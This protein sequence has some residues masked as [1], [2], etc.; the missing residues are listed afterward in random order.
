[1]QTITFECEV[2]TPM[3]LAGADG[4]TPEL[5][6]PSIKGALRFWWRAMNGHKD[7]KTLQEEE[8]KIFGGT[9]GDSGQRSNVLIRVSCDDFKP[10]Y[11]M[12]TYNIKTYDGKYRNINVLFYL[13]YGHTEYKKIEGRGQTV[14]SHAFIP[15]KTKF[16]VTLKVSDE[17]KKDMIEAFV[18]VSQF[19]G[20]GSKSRNGFGC[21]S[22]NQI[23]DSANKK[24]EKPII[25]LKSFAEID[26]ASFTAFSK[27]TELYETIEDEIDWEGYNNWHSAL[28]AIGASYQGSRESLDNPHHTYN[29]RLYI[30]QPIEVKGTKIPNFLERH[31]K[32]LF[33]NIQKTT[34]G[35]FS[36]KVLFMPYKFI[37]GHPDFEK[38]EI[39]VHQKKYDVQMKNFKNSFVDNDYFEKM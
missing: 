12:P 31:S 2:I 37:E 27:A 16:R 19:S 29:N 17:L 30:A 1:M 14:L 35:K 15:P 5:R 26:L 9:S 13:A 18:A 21:F 34:N 25:S 22:I 23:L 3:F 11:E 28:G 6:A 10:S 32:S 33:I 20:I 36:A 39:V 7:L 4:I 8:T 24:L 38:S